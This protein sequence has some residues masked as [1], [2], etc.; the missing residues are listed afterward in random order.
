MKGIA[1]S[2]WNSTLLSLILLFVVLYFAK[3]II[4]LIL[5]AMLLAML[6]KPVAAKLEKKGWKR[7]W[8]TLVCLLIL[9]CAFGAII[10]MITV[11]TKKLT[12]QAPVIKPKAEKFKKDVQA[13]IQDKFGFTVEQ[14][15]AAIEEQSKSMSQ[16][17]KEMGKKVVVGLAG[18]I[19]SF[20]LVLVFTC[21]FLFQREKYKSFIL[22]LYNGKNFQELEDVITKISGV[23]QKY[24]TGMSYSIMI[25][26]TLYSI[27]FLI[28]GLQNPILL[29]FTASVL[30]IIPYVGAWIGGLIPFSVALVTGDMNMALSVAGILIAVQLIDNNFIEPYVVGGEVRLSFAATLLALLTGGALWGIA[31]VILFVPL[32]GISKIIF[33][34]IEPLKPYGFLIGDTKKAPSSNFGNLFRGIIRKFQR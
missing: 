30:V 8:S 22:R 5:F 10:T 16:S 9:L 13:F 20:L 18:T 32:T 7:F 3:D 25:L 33:D 4:I 34:H 31:G 6:V 21:L 17:A 24:L 2:K 12:E 27:G 26:T 28:I 1:L 29:A 14:Q 15:N 23:A 11:E 19:A